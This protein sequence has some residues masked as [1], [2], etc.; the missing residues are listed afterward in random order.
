[1]GKVLIIRESPAYKD[2]TNIGKYDMPGGKIEPGENFILGLQREVR[3]ECGLEVTMG[4]P[5]HVAE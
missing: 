1:M 2:G 4:K 3:E 5:I